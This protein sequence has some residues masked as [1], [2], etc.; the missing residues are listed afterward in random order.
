M[1][2]LDDGLFFPMIDVRRSDPNDPEANQEIR[3][4]HELEMRQQPQRARIVVR[5]K[6]KGK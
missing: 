5:G 6:E 1:T 4:S 3:E 2:V